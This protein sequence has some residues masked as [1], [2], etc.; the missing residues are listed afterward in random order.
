MVSFGKSLERVAMRLLG[1][2]QMSVT[3]A[4]RRSVLACTL[5]VLAIAG[6]LLGGPAVASIG[7]PDGVAVIIGNSNYTGTGKVQFAHRD[8]AAFRRYVLGVLGFDAANVIYL[9][10]A[11]QAQMIG[12]FGSAQDPRGKLWFYLDPDVG[13][14]ASDVVVFY[15][16]PG[17]PGLNEKTPGAYLLPT[18]ANPSNPRL[19]GYSVELLYRNLSKLPARRVSVFLDACFTGRGGDGKPHLKSVANL[20]EGGPAGQRRSQYDSPHGGETRPVGILG[21]EGRPQNVHSSPAGCTLRQGR[22]Q[23]G[24]QG[25]GRGSGEAPETS[26]AKG[27]TANLPERPGCKIAGPDRKRFG[28]P[29]IG[30]GRRFSPNVRQFG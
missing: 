10:D 4:M 20:P 18:D 25:D 5:C 30:G 19:N 11:S 2:Q 16:G 3:I 6:G 13:R 12:V 23:P 22:R 29:G 1:E 27:G 8:A 14:K 26:H 21:H 17:M 9:Q 15:S 7:N 24:W 28:R